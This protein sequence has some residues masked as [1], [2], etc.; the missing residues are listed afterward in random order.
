M[1]HSE[2]NAMSK[3][4]LVRLVET[5]ATCA[6]SAWE[7]ADELAAKADELY[8]SGNFGAALQVQLFW[9]TFDSALKMANLQQFK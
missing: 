3:R 8:A 6:K 2:I 9:Q 7:H 4:D 5:I 1:T